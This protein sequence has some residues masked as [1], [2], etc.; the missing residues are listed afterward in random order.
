MPELLQTEKDPCLVFD[1]GLHHGQDTD[2]YLKKGFRV[3]AFEADPS[4]AAFCRERFAVAINEGRLTIVEGAITEDAARLGIENVKF[5]RN[6][7]H[8]LWGSTN[9]D[10][11]ARNKVLGTTN[12]IIE[13]AAVDFG[14]CVEQYGV[15]HYLKADIV[16]SE[17]ICLRALLR[18]ESK[19][20]YI[21]IRSEKLVF[22]KL[23]TEFDLL[24]KLG[25]D[26]F[27]AVKQD[28][29]K[30]R[31]DLGEG[32][33]SWEEGASG[34]FGEE[35]AG[36][37]KSRGETVG[38][39]RSIFVKYWLFGDYSYLIQT[40]RGRRF[41]TRLERVTRRSI[42]GW[43]DTHAVHS[44]LR[45]EPSAKPET[46]SLKE[47]SAWLLMAKIIGFAFSFM[48]PLVIVRY[49]TQDAVGH[50]R[51]AFQVIMNATTILPMGVS[52]SAYYFLARETP[53]RRGAAVFNILI[54]NFVVGGLAC[55]ALNFYPQ[56][57]GS[58]FQADEMTAL[59][60]KIGAIIWI[61]IF[62]TFLET[63]A[64]ANQ[65]ARVATAFIIASQFSKTLLMGAAVFAFGTVE[66]FMYAA[67][68][69]G[70][71]QTFILLNYIRSRF[72]GFWRGF[73][74]GFFREQ[75]VYAIPFGI[76]A[77]VWIAQND[78]HN[79]FV[80][81]KFSS[82]DFA[83]YAYGCFEI[84]LMTMLAESVTSVLIPRMNA[85]QQAGDREEMIRLTARAMQ[86]L[87]FFYFPIYVFL[88]ITANTF[89]IT[90]F[91]Q[92]YEASASVFV[93]NL[94]LLPLSIL[95]TDPIVRSYKELGRLFLLTR[96]LVLAGLVSVLYCGLGSF[97]LQ[98]MITSAV[99]AI[100]I[101]KCITETLVFRKLGI[102]F[103]DL[104]L[105]RNVAKTAV[106]SLIAGAITYLVYANVHEYF[107]GVGER[108]AEAA[109]STTKLATLDFIGGGLVLLISA[110]VFLPVYL[111]AANLWGLIEDNEKDSVRRMVRKVMPK[112]FVEPAV[113][114]R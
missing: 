78:I 96:I 31:S 88:M 110:S 65:E 41:I 14:K 68:I 48:L 10:W 93:I 64:I 23:E 30:V 28:F 56:L 60:P 101:E 38:D 33:Y 57:L 90:L 9:E 59:A 5:Y 16:G 99:G 85:L 24:E 108:F 20:D 27:K 111:I 89:I 47:Q 74:V 66:A 77:I 51:E 103:K 75:L 63:I 104:P 109:F 62:S 69:Q 70:V 97:G 46:A 58:L 83:I 18:F 92:K 8:S 19:P 79:Y 37:W 29:E 52:M 71:V 22:G 54:F 50:Y 39:Y 42:P 86:K 113:Q 4:N 43:Y 87:A 15:P 105:L 82:S 91:T 67:M 35:T 94:T 95:I 25:Y 44:S 40:T 34:P 55:L 53:A 13:V 76:A 81:Y 12:E 102:G 114:T 98:G 2:F 49:L 112:R 84:P 3:V 45:E 26:R 80:G 36:T 32:L 21:S 107:L 100:I 17:T 11:A 72:P 61:W 73:S 1:V 6:E 106:A 7:D